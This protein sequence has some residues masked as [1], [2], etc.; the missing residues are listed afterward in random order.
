[1]TNRCSVLRAGNKSHRLFSHHHFACFDIPE[2][3]VEQ[4]EMFTVYQL[5][6]KLSLPYQLLFKCK[7]H[8]LFLKQESTTKFLHSLRQR[9]LLSTK[10]RQSA[11][12]HP[13]IYK[14]LSSDKSLLCRRV[15]N[16]KLLLQRANKRHFR[17][18]IEMMLSDRKTRLGY[19]FRNWM[20]TRIRIADYTQFDYSAV[21][22]KVIKYFYSEKI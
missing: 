8:E 16:A 7:M 2:R 1:M 18:L 21:E 20:L 5:K 22:C 13:Q 11:Q 6:K 12:L 14:N 9:Y 3:D 17:F 4:N 10:E 19:H 15:Q